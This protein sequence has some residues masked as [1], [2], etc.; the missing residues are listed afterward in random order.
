MVNPVFLE[1]G[2]AIALTRHLHPP[3]EKPRRREQKAVAQLGR[4]V[5]VFLEGRDRDLL[6]VRIVLKAAGCQR[7]DR[8]IDLAVGARLQIGI[9]ERR[10][11]REVERSGVEPL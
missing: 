9:G 8:L 6:D 5:G 11:A 3:R 2:I 4:I 7:D 1:T 10:G